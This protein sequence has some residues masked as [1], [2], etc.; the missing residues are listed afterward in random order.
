MFLDIRPAVELHFKSLK[1]VRRVSLSSLT[2]DEIATILDG[3]EPLIV[4]GLD[5][6]WPVHLRRASLRE[7]AQ[8]AR[9][10]SSVHID[11]HQHFDTPASEF[12]N[13][14]EAGRNVRIFGVKLTHDMNRAFCLPDRLRSRLA[15]FLPADEA[16]HCFIGGGGAI[17]PLHYD[18]ELHANWHYVLSGR[19]RVYLWTYDQSPL[20]FKLPIIGLTTIPFVKGRLDY[21]FAKGREC[22]LDAGDLLYMPPRC[23]HQ[24]E[25]PEPSMAF[26]YSFHRR[27]RRKTLGIFTGYFWKGVMTLE[28][29]VAARRPAAIILTPLILPL[30]AF[31][32]AYVPIRFASRLLLGRASFVVDLPCQM[33]EWSLFLIYYPLFNWA[34]RKMW[35]GY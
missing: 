5:Q 17:T 1:P 7:I 16:P 2:D 20:L 14:L 33:I 27:K 22:V 32:V 3:D 30:L 24:I 11:G 28:Q 9:Q 12:F 15:Q 18:F 29:A 6:S 4:E 35:V 21:R 8:F 10:P 34:R 26:T 25:Y 13:M 19:R 31:S 23:W